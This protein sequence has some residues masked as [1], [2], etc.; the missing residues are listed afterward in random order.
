MQISQA[1]FDGGGGDDDDDDNVGAERVDCERSLWCSL[2]KVTTV[3]P[4]G[5][6][7]PAAPQLRF[8]R[9]A[10]QSPRHCSLPCHER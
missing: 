1:G 3:V 5:L 10:L 2:P 6:V 9:I 7:Y 8:D 4:R